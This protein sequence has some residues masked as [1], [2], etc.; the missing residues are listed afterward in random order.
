M[1]ILILSLRKRRAYRCLPLLA[2]KAPRHV[3]SLNDQSADGRRAGSGRRLGQRFSALPWADT[4]PKARLIGNRIMVSFAVALLLLPVMATSAEA[5]T[6]RHHSERR[7]AAIPLAS[8]ITEAAQRFGVPVAW[9]YAVIRV[10][11]GG[12]VHAISPKSAMGLMQIMPETYAELRLRHGL[13]R[14]PYDPRDNILAGA[15][16]LR[17]MHDRYG[18]PGFLA[19]YN[20][21][22]GRYEEHVETGRPLPAETRVYVRTIASMLGLKQI[23]RITGI[24]FAAAD[25]TPWT[26]GPLFAVQVIIHQLLSDRD[27]T[28]SDKRSRKLRPHR[29]SNMRFAVDVT[30]LVPQKTGLFVRRSAQEA[31][32]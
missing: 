7:S 28:R 6:Y 23:D 12:N 17:E 20:A 26:G 19:A 27:T 21:G 16:Y 32:P 18:S 1:G 22:P 29:S 4:S 2:S 24:T 5:F 10:E 8:F 14:N 11:S 15:A 3:V 30:A 9:I 31:L 25:P 13:G